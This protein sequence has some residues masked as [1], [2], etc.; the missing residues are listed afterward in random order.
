MAKKRHVRYF[1]APLV[2][3]PTS[4]QS[5]VVNP[6]TIFLGGERMPDEN[7]LNLM[8]SLGKTIYP[9]FPTHG[10]INKMLVMVAMGTRDDR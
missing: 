10:I 8:F 9:S 6:P 5:Y 3:V 7:L 2:P 1:D 4:L